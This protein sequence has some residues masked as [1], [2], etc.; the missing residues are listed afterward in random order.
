MQIR[1]VLWGEAEKSLPYFCALS[2]YVSKSAKGSLVIFAI[3][4]IHSM[5]QD[6]PKKLLAIAKIIYFNSE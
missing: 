1:N 3:R 6:Q 2:M 5:S 4:Q